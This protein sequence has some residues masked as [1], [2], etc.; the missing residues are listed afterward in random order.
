MV[1]TSYN[2]IGDLLLLFCAGDAGWILGGPVAQAEGGNGF[3][4]RVGVGGAKLRHVGYLVFDRRGSLHNLY[5][6]YNAGFAVWQR[7]DGVLRSAVCGNHV[8]VHDDGAAAAV[9]SLSPSRLRNICGLCR[10]TVRKPLADDCDCADR[11]AGADAVYCTATGGDPGRDRSDGGAGG[12]AAGC[13][14][15][16]SGGVY[17]LERFAGAGGDCDCERRDALC[18]GAGSTDLYSD[19]AGRVCAGV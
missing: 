13:G 12:V 1:A 18:D 8:S 7:S 3:A 15:C 17:L 2:G 11:S 14:V 9:D 10:W 19:Q 5:G 6:D 4:R 16:D